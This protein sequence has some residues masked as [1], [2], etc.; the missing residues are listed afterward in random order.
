[1]SIT[2]ANGG[3]G[4]VVNVKVNERN[5]LYVRSTST[6]ENLAATTRG[7]SYNINTGTITL[8][9]SVDTPVLYL[10]NNENPDLHI[11]A[12][13]IGLGTETGGTATQSL[14]ITIVRN[15]TAGTIVSNATAVAINSNRNFGSSN[16][17]LADAYKGATGSTMTDGIDHLFIYAADFG[18]GF[19]EIDSVLTKGDSIGVKI[20][21]TAGNSSLPL[22]CALICHL[23]DEKA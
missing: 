10:K 5:E 6:Q 19:F 11:V 23:E 1:M 4:P 17:L 12:V 13:A 15:P 16:V 14:E 2:I 22:Y 7:K 20:N 8:T 3:D 21:P 18:R 9:D